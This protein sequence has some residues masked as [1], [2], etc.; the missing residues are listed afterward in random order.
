M[1]AIEITTNLKSGRVEYMLDQLLGCCG[2]AVIAHPHFYI[3][4][5]KEYVYI[6]DFYDYSNK[7]RALLKEKLL[8]LY[9]E[10]NNYIQSIPS[11]YHVGKEPGARYP[12][13]LDRSLVLMTGPAGCEAYA[14]CKHNK[15]KITQ[16]FVNY[17]TNNT[18]Y[19]FTLKRR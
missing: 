15:W 14:F 12:F 2:V 7:E 10:F 18:V 4:Y 5:K 1:T 17:K 11:P 13:N 9:T 3:K 16:R 19:T 8:K 6:N